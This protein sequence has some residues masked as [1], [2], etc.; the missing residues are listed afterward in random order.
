MAD[1]TNRLP[2]PI[3]KKLAST[4]T[5]IVNRN[6][7]EIHYTVAGIPFRVATSPD[8]PMTFETAQYQKDQQD[9]EPEAGEQTLSGWW[10][11]SQVSWNEGAGALFSEARGDV[12]ATAAFRESSNVDVWTAGELRLLKATVPIST[13]TAR[14]VAIVPTA[15]AL[16]TVVGRV[17]SVT[18]YTN[19]DTGTASTNLY[20]NGAVTF[21]QV[22][23]TETEWFGAGNDGKVYSGPIGATTTSPKIWTLNAAGSG[24]TRI[25]WAKHRLWATNGNKIYECVYAAP[26]VMTATYSHPSAGWVYTDIADGPGGVLFSG[27]GDGTSCLQRISIDT[28]GGI[29]TLSGAT[30]VA[31]LPTDEKILRVSELAGSMFCMVTNMGVRVAVADSSGTVT[32]GPL[33]LER[34]TEVPD[35]TVPAICSAGRFWWLSFGDE[36]KLW[37]VDSSAEIDEG[38]FAYASDME[39]ASAPVSVTVRKGRAVVATVSGAVSYQHASNL[40][41]SGFIQTGRIRF[42]T[43]E[44]KT[45]HYIDVTAA[46]L[47]GSVTLDTLN[48]ADSQANVL[49]WSEQ[50]HALPSAQFPA[51][52]GQQRFV[53]L[54]FTLQPDPGDLTAGPVIYG[55]RVKALPAARPQRIYTLPLLCY[56]DEEWSTGQREGYD[57]FG[58]DRY[59]AV[60]AAEDAG[61]VVLLVDY[62]FTQ[63]AGELCRIESMKFVQLQQ[64]DD[65]Q[66]TGGLAGVL[67]VTLRTLT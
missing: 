41:A 58:R 2:F 29:P 20:I 12:A 15:T 19:M 34:D 7:R 49:T 28:D 27:Y 25:C 47:A 9:Q 30:T 37:R 60:R 1:V 3:S 18:R 44:F 45:Y 24:P 31:Q 13:T 38:V 46:P 33:F 11:R 55:V 23:A 62:Q 4:V 53:S 63:P 61:G 64:P 54:K 16:S 51:T 42:R 32:Y 10:L 26:G 17:G 39:S 35:T 67:I 66:I 57:G 5:E 52:F 21:T 6:G 50:G 43:D 59:L 65:R 22:I 8:L 40:C 14:S 36:N 48:D 56:D